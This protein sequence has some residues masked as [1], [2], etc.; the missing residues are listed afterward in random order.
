M[1]PIDKEVVPLV[2]LVALCTTFS[3]GL[4]FGS[5]CSGPCVQE[6]CSKRTLGNPVKTLE[7]GFCSVVCFLPE[8]LYSLPR[9][10]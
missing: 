1:S 3:G 2:T 8:E 6:V 7:A 10:V 9:P 5:L 4:Q